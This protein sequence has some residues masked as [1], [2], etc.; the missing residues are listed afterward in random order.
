MEQ[1]KSYDAAYDQAEESEKKM[2]I[3]EEKE[4]PLSLNKKW[5]RRVK[6]VDGKSINVYTVDGDYVRDKYYNE[7][8]MGG[9]GYRYKFIPKS[10]VWLEQ[11][12]DDQDAEDT[13][14]HEVKESKLMA[15]GWS[16]NK[17]HKAASSTEKHKREKQSDQL[18]NKYVNP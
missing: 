12:L 15:K 9:N 8:T 7:F 5:K 16:Y 2:S 18:E 6:G 17:A 4:H 1:G 3:E 11:C 10:E 14:V 13:L